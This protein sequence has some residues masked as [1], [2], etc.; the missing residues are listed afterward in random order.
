[1]SALVFQRNTKQTN[2]PATRRVCLLIPESEF[3]SSSLAV[4]Q[5]NSRGSSA[6]GLTEPSRTQVTS[7]K[8]SIHEAYPHLCVNRLKATER[9]ANL[10]SLWWFYQSYRMAGK[11][12]FCTKNCSH[13]FGLP[14]A[15]SDFSFLSH[16]APLRLSTENMELKR[17]STGH[18]S[19]YEQFNYMYSV[20]SFRLLAST[21][22]YWEPPT[23]S[24]V[25]NWGT[26]LSCAC[27]WR[28]WSSS[29]LVPDT[30]AIMSNSIVPQW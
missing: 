20:L 15:W 9:I 13:T 12:F 28:T 27:L 23:R 4:E 18:P 25:R 29:A 2:H 11:N 17:W 22:P 3:M 10:R 5:H 26:Q 6:F 8:N 19:N 16:T 1:V 14:G 24:H 7:L 21:Q 30:R